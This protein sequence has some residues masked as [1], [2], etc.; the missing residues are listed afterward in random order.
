MTV[1]TKGRKTHGSPAS[2]HFVC[3]RASSG[4]GECLNLQWDSSVIERHF[5]QAFPLFMDHYGQEV[6]ELQFQEGLEHGV[7]LTLVEKVYDEPE[8]GCTVRDEPELLFEFELRHKEL[9]TYVERSQQARGAAK[10]RLKEK[11]ERA[12]ELTKLG[13]LE[14][15][16][17]GYTNE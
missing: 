17:A 4:G 10:R 16:I 12:E 15:V 1:A 7:A 11:T 8:L 9:K 6:L 5:K 13:L 14:G 3:T 2:T